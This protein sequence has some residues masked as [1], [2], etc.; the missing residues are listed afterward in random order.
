MPSMNGSVRIGLR[1]RST[2]NLVTGSV[3]HEGALEDSAATRTHSYG[4][5]SESRL[6]SGDGR[7]TAFWQSGGYERAVMLLLR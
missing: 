4:R 5:V 3:V 2:V 1:R 7:R 6:F